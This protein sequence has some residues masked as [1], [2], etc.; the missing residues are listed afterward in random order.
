[1]E[2][3]KNFKPEYLL[4]GKRFWPFLGSSRNAPPQGAYG[5]ALCDNPKNGCEANYAICRALNCK[6]DILK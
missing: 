2:F 3:P 5:G 4:N 6:K 1:M